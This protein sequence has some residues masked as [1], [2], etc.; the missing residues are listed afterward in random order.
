MPRRVQDI[1]P[2]N[3]RSIRD[4]PV[5]RVVDIPKKINKKQEQEVILDKPEP[6]KKRKN[7]RSLSWF[8]GIL[9]IVVVIAGIAFG[10]SG[11][12]ATATFNLVAKVL[13][14]SINGTYIIPSTSS[15][16]SGTFGYEV[17]SLSGTASTTVAANQGS[18]T[19]TKAQ[20]SITLYNSFSSQSQKIVAGTRLA[21]NSGLVYRLTS[22]VIVP[23]YITSGVTA[24]PGSIN[25]SIIADQAGNQY[26]IS[27]SDSISD[28]KIIAYKGTAKYSGFYGRLNGDVSGGFSG[29]QTV[30]VPTLLASTTATLQSKL[31]S[32]LL[33]KIK[34]SIPVG[35]VMY[36]NI[37]STSF[38]NPVVSTIDSKTAKVSVTSTLYGIILNKNN[39]AKFLAGA[40]STN[41]F[42]ALGYTE[43]NIES[44]SFSFANQ[45]DFSVLKKTN[46]ITRVNGSFNLVG[47]IPTN[48]LKQ[49]FAGISIGS[50]GDILKKYAAVIDI[51]HSSAEINP[52]WVSTVPTDQN[53]ITINIKTP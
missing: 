39:L 30:V 24:I 9:G 21:N 49:S 44:L 20:G 40:S 18:F 36:P 53:R 37:Y 14:V 31:T 50:T 1:I 10:I 29:T 22:S 46:L 12:F 16:S 6:K 42:G 23:G 35:S 4:I 13:P 2:S 47:V 15:T 26:N 52:P 45:K 8:L 7:S 51:L 27:G 5:D 33:N 41:M 11:H 43:P 25:G 38:T 34:V 17:V 28:F 48:A 32:D 3:R 19:Q